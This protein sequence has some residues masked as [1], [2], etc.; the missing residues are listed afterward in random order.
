MIK[1]ATLVILPLIT[2]YITWYLWRI[3]VAKPKVDPVTGDQLIP[4]FDRAPKGRLLLASFILLILVIGGFLLIH[5]RFKEE[6]YRPI[7]VK[8]YERQEALQD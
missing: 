3:F 4:E 2:P 8:E 6:P 1:F 7:D 5:D